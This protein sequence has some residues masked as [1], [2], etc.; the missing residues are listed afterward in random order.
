MADNTVTQQAGTQQAAAPQGAEAAGTQAHVAVEH[1]EPELLGVAPPVAVVS[2]SMLVLIAIMLWKGVPKL[3]TGGLD[4]RISQI[5][6]HLEEAKTLRAEA[7]ALRKEYAD[8]IANAEKDA[9]AMLEHAQHEAEA[10]VAKAEA[11]TTELIARRR[12]MVEEKIS[13]LELATITDLRRKAAAAAAN[14][15]ADLIKDNH[16]AAADKALVDQAIAGI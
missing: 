3:I 4:A 6:A 2:T 15:A 13:A 11:D 8:K 14:A 9:A 5:K 10:I 1:A 7:E 16:S 12:K